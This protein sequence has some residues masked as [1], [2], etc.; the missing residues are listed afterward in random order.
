MVI[1]VDVDVAS[2]AGGEDKT[3][4]PFHAGHIRGDVRV[5]GLW[6]T[7][8]GLAARAMVHRE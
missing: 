2:L 4:V 3:G 5:T 6:K 1:V 7:V 8:T